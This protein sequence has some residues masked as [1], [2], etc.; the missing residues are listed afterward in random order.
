MKGWRSQISDQKQNNTTSEHKRSY[1]LIFT[2][3]EN[4]FCAHLTE[5]GMEVTEA[6]CADARFN[7]K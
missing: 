3:N 7:L 5:V 6:P 2:I 1:S 4:G